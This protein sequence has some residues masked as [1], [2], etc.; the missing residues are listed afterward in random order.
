MLNGM[1]PSPEE[2]AMMEAQGLA[3][4]PPLPPDAAVGAPMEPAMVDNSLGALPP[5]ILEIIVMM[6][7]G[8]GG[9]PAEQAPM[10]PIAEQLMAGGPGMDG[11]TLGMP[12]G[13]PPMDD[14]VQ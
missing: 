4:A 9:M 6:L 2:M 14:V 11:A 7:G 8:G 3:A 5:E 12:S 1:E 10:N 13:L